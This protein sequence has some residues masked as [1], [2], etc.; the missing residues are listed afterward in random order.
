MADG[1]V[2]IIVE[3][4]GVEK[5]TN[6]FQKFNSTVRMSGKD[7]QRWYILMRRTEK[8][9]R[10][11]AQTMDRMTRS[12]MRTSKAFKQGS[13]ALGGFTGGLFTLSNMIR[14]G[15]FF[16]LINQVQGLARE[17]ATAKTHMEFRSAEVSIEA[18]SR[19][20]EVAEFR[21]KNLRK[22]ADEY[23]QDMLGVMKQAK[24][25]Y[26]A[27]RG[28]QIGEEDVDKVLEGILAAA[29]AMQIPQEQMEGSIFAITQM[30]SKGV[31][32]MEEMRRQL[33]E[34]LPG[35]I[36]VAA[37][38]MNMTQAELVELIKTGKLAS[39]EFI[40]AFGPQLLKEFQS[41]AIKASKELRAEFARMMNSFKQFKSDVGAME[42]GLLNDA[43][44]LLSQ[45]FEFLSDKIVTAD[46][47]MDRFAEKHVRNLN[48]M[49]SELSKFAEQDTLI[50]TYD[51]LSKK[52]DKSTEENR[53][54]DSVINQ[55]ASTFPTAITQVDAYGKAI[56]IST[57]RVKKMVNAQRKLTEF[58]LTQKRIEAIKKIEEEKEGRIDR[59]TRI[60]SISEGRGPL[61][62][63]ESEA[64]DLI[65]KEGIKRQEGL[66]TSSERLFRRQY[67]E[68]VKTL[69][70]AQLKAVS[71]VLGIE[72][73][74]GPDATRL[75]REASISASL[76]SEMQG[77]K[78]VQ[79]NEELELELALLEAREASIEAAEELIKGE[80]EVQTTLT[81]SSK[82]VIPFWIEALNSIEFGTIFVNE[83]QRA[84]EDMSMAIFQG[85]ITAEKAAQVM[86]DL[87]NAIA[88]RMMR[89]VGEGIAGDIISSI[90]SQITTPGSVTPGAMTVTP[91]AYRGAVIGKN[92]P[93]FANGGVV[94]ASMG[95]D[96]TMASVRKGEMVINAQQQRQLWN[97]A[98]GRGG[99]QSVQIN[100]KII[101]QAPGVEV[102][103][104][105]GSGPTDQ[106]IFIRRVNSVI[107][108]GRADKQLSSSTSRQKGVG[109]TGG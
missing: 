105:Q 32:S 8:N 38:A 43:V 6:Q 30:I 53:R 66:F 77:G 37:R 19:N 74:L 46:V 93:H 106:E 61:L 50:D 40:V 13:M 36:G 4:R 34:R 20:M 26:G 101:N 73:A 87:G 55:L 29:T 45:S 59:K 23:G 9:T 63:L 58:E 18:L 24:Q 51:E 31:V 42:T 27:A 16:A 85:T 107:G 108:S 104:R 81:K 103:T 14:G 92:M 41:G 28:T 25:L 70:E 64:Q 71:D 11:T 12:A 95:P 15:V 102:E 94:G 17:L 7:L 68:V 88:A 99:G 22:L 48:K 78:T 96:N 57:D 79:R 39:D 72:S 97:T 33:G 35:A 56:G 44:N 84:F 54:L 80:K 89:K 10:L 60:K 21:L 52:T 2:R 1:K 5:A 47:R 3:Q 49:K 82:V 98:N 86:R 91:G 69:S 83:F 65:A 90:S 100:N 62:E 76:A 67:L 75:Q 109:I